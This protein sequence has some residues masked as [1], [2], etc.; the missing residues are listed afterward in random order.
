MSLDIDGG[1]LVRYLKSGGLLIGRTI[2]VLLTMTLAT[3]M[4]AREGPVP[5]AG[6]QICVQLWLTV[7]L[8]TDALALAGQALLATGYSQG[9]YQGARQVVYRLI[10]E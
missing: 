1:R 9:N 3:S 8:L 4:A 10:Q 5:M 6:Y 7:S 2:A